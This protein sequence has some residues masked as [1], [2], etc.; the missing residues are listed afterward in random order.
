M[1]RGTDN[2][3]E[4]TFTARP[5]LIGNPGGDTTQVLSTS[6]ELNQL[7]HNV[8]LVLATTTSDT[9]RGDWIERTDILHCFNLL[10]SYQ[11]ESFIAAAKEFHIPVVLSPIYWDMTM[12]ERTARAVGGW[13]A[14]AAKAG[15]LLRTPFVRRIMLK[16]LK[17]VSYN[18]HY[19]QHLG[20][21]L[22][23][24]DMLLPNSRA[25]THVLERQFQFETASHIVLNGCRFHETGEVVHPL[26]SL[27]KPFVLCVGRIEQ[28]KNQLGL[29]RALEGM[30]LP[31][32]FL[33][34]VN[35]AEKNY[36]SECLK[37]ANEV[38]VQVIQIDGRE[39]KD[40]WHYYRSAALHIQPSWFE[41]PGLS[42]LE[43]AAAGCRI[44]CTKYGSA[45]EYFEKHADYCD[46]SD[47]ASIRHAILTS[48]QR[49][50]DPS[51]LAEFV[52]KRYTWKNA[53][54]ST[55]E[56]YSTVESLIDERT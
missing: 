44:V 41:T 24:V 10:L 18:R 45:A 38:S 34:N 26:P 9:E 11:F 16:H 14:I 4:I 25:E 50:H 32:V 55:L 21:I 46:P 2:G 20:Q 17:S 8:R 43:A 15:S 19:R 48:L 23:E 5:D 37:T 3:Y 51:C 27:R 36:W 40:V 54:L 33:G 1:R 12:Y 49:D 52:R 42:S 6:D 7:G 29:I 35:L 13:K 47:T 22:G 56:S 28:R 39:W 30:D 31:L 53:A